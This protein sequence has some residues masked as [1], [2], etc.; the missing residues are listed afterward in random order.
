VAHTATTSNSAFPWRPDLSVFA[1]QDVLP[2]AV[3]FTASTVSGRIEG[4]EP[5]LR[6][7][8]I[9]DDVAEFVDEGAPFDESSPQ[10]NE[11]VIQ[12]RKFGQLVRLSR[13]QFSQNGTP[14]SLSNSVA[15]SMT[16]K[17]DQAFLTQAAPTS[18]AIAPVA[19]L[20]N[21][22]GLVTKSGVATDLDDLIDLEATLRQNLAMPALW[23]VAPDTWAELRKLKVADTYNSNL[24][25]AGTDDAQPLLL[26]MPVLVNNQMPSRTGL[27]VDPREVI[28]AVSDLT[29]A[30][31]DQTYWSSDSYGIRATMRTGHVVP[32]PNRLGL[33]TMPA[34][35]T[36]TLGS[37]SAGTWTATFA[38]QTTSALDKAIT[39][40]NLKV[41][42]AALSDAWAAGDWVVSGSSGGPYT[43]TSP[44]GTLTG[45]GAGLTGGT[46]S[47]V[48]A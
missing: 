38:G 40:A 13:E 42:L 7:A 39:A 16:I 29:I 9:V 12:T 5:S 10:L 20:T 3:I 18:P 46:F 41:A 25:G 1:P 34:S 22:T 45:S 31:S 47:V 24:L 14:D 36:I 44:G 4:D 35:W 19:G 30:V 28:S 43:I 6:V 2:S 32:R 23:V 21:T 26:S 8:F 15:R 33:F 11:A 17:A 37:P 48:A 27:L